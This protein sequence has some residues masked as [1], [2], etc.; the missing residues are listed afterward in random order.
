MTG[1]EAEDLFIKKMTELGREV[2]SSTREEN[3]AH[4]DYYVD[5]ISYDVKTEKKLNRWDQ[6]TDP[7]LIWLEMKNVRGDVGWLCSNVQKIAFLRKDKFYIIDREKLLN[8]AREFIGHGRIYDY[9][10]Y[11]ALYSRYGRN[12]LV[13]FVWWSDIEHLL[14]EII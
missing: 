10:K 3:M 1:R 12:D 4:V 14:E 13:A 6:E 11:R 7:D 8:F 2:I 5:K 9:K